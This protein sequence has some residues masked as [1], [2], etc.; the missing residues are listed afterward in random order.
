MGS[1]D[2]IG[3]INKKGTRQ[4]EVE[5]KKS[6]RVMLYR[7]RDENGW[8]PGPMTVP[9]RTA[10]RISRWVAHNNTVKTASRL[11][12]AHHSDDINSTVDNNS[13]F[14]NFSCN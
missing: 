10:V 13:S 2:K 1:T 12:S 7:V 8:F 6:Y 4:E 11:N 9:E 5:E 14:K 3:R